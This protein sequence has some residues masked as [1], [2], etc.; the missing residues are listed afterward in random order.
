MAVMPSSQE[1]TQWWQD[2]RFT[3]RDVREALELCTE[4]CDNVRKFME[5]KLITSTY[6][7]H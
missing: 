7:Q 1:V 3:G 2:G 5:A 6:L 4:G